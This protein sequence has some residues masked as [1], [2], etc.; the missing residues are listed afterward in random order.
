[1][2]MT[3][4]PNTGMLSR[5]W[6]LPQAMQAAWS[7]PWASQTSCLGVVTDTAHTKAAGPGGLRKL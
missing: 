7:Q 4:F 2:K 3:S 5:G 1:M 6:V